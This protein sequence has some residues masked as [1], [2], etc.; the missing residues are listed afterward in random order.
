MGFVSV[1]QSTEMAQLAS[2]IGFD[3]F[4]SLVAFSGPVLAIWLE[5]MLWDMLGDENGKRRRWRWRR[6]ARN[7]DGEDEPEED[8]WLNWEGG[9][10]D[11][12]DG[13][14]EALVGGR[15]NDGNNTNINYDDNFMTFSADPE[16]SFPADDVY[17]SDQPEQQQQDRPL[18]E[19]FDESSSPQGRASMDSG[20]RLIQFNNNISQGAA[21][22]SRSRPA[23]I[24]MPAGVI[25]H[26]PPPSRPGLGNNS[27]TPTKAFSSFIGLAILFGGLRLMVSSPTFW[28]RPI[29]E[30]QSRLVATG[31]VSSQTLED[32]EPLIEATKVMALGGAQLIVWSEAAASITED[33]DDGDGTPEDVGRNRNLEEFKVTIRKLSDKLNVTLVASAMHKPLKE[34]PKKLV[35]ITSPEISDPI[36][37]E[38]RFLFPFRESGFGRGSDGYPSFES[39]TLGRVAVTMTYEP[40]RQVPKNADLVIE[41]ASDWGPT[42]SLLALLS[43]SRGLENGYTLFRCS[44]NGAT[45][46]SNPFGQVVFNVQTAQETV[47]LH[48]VVHLQSQVKTWYYS[49]GV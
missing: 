22:T 17:H 39:V 20:D 47:P 43:R 5:R 49:I 11:G 18:L 15:E 34:K 27:W 36:V 29:D 16:F 4:S 31:C 1:S 40:V 2:L 9:G 41:V 30:T 35:F 21:T 14:E 19:F 10:E 42:G 25:G 24:R 44:S 23:S 7:A 26:V 3:G 48:T 28:Q 33:K 12:E 6:R 8:E 32:F 37:Y 46:A 13:E 38:K 45:I